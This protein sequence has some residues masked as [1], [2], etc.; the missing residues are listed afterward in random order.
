MVIHELAH[1][2]PITIMWRL[3]NG[4]LQIRRGTARRR[5]TSQTTQNCALIGDGALPCDKRE[6][7]GTTNVDRTKVEGRR[8]RFRKKSLL[9]MGDQDR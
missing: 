6:S 1:L 7:S 3:V 8:P 2:F 9:I 4:I 5:S